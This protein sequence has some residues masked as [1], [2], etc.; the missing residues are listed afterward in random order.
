MTYR[1]KNIGLAVLLA[2]F[3]GL[4]TIFYVA[5][6]KRHVQHDE[7][8]VTVLVAARDIPAGTTGSEV[9][10]QHYLKTESVAR[11]TVVPGA[12]SK[13]DDLNSLV[14]TETVYRGEQ[15]TATRFGTQTELGIRAQ[16]HGTDRAMQLDGSAN[17]LLAG[18]LQKGDYV[19]VVA[20]F[21]TPDGSQHHTSRIIARNLYV[22][23]APATPEGGGKLGS[24][25]DTFS[26]QLR[27]SDDA[28]QAVWYGRQVGDLSL[29]LR[30]PASDSRN[31]PR[32]TDDWS[33]L[34]DRGPDMP[35]GSKVNK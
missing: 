16:L 24:S 22:L 30:P 32:E 18:T 1:V 10:E 28:M 9:V 3:A 15:L 29:L 25:T 12:Y 35:L 2:A 19:D 34:L 14:A 33:T 23:E 27:G 6:Y 21:T 11:R 20:T 4:L 8:N 31:S 13:P 26:V 17:A 7:K 5:N